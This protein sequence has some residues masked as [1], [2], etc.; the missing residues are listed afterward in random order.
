MPNIK[1]VV[2]LSQLAQANAKI[3]SLLLT[4]GLSNV[5]SYEGDDS[6]RGQALSGQ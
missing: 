5:A 6:L 2:T 3:D 4:G 1:Y